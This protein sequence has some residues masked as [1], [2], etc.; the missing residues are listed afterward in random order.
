MESNSRTY[1]I[2]ITNGEILDTPIETNQQFEITA[3]QRELTQLKGKRK[4][5]PTCQPDGDRVI[6]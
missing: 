3:N 4:I 6:I 1:Y 5:I 2:D